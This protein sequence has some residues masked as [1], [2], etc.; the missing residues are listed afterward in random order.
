MLKRLLILFLIL[1]MF[2][3]L[4]SCSKEV[5]AKYL[6]DELGF[7]TETLSSW[8]GEIKYIEENRGKFEDTYSKVKYNP[9]NPSE[10]L[11]FINCFEGAQT[12]DAPDSFVFSAEGMSEYII[13]FYIDGAEEPALSFYY[14]KGG[15]LLTRVLRSFDEKKQIEI[16]EYEFYEPYGDLMSVLQAQREV[17]IEPVSEFS[18]L[19]YNQKQLVASVEEE[20]LSERMT[21]FN[22]VYEVQENAELG[23]IEFEIY[24]GELPEDEGT[25]CKLYDNSDI[26]GLTDEQVVLL[27]RIADE[28]G[29]PMELLI[30][31]V[32][33]NTYYTIVTV[34]YPDKELMEQL[35]LE[36]DN[37]ILLNKEDINPD[38][39]IVFLDDEGD[40]IYVVVP[41]AN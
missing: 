22:D 19:S 20:E 34:A 12:T 2:F 33:Y 13:N 3:S 5:H 18:S 37:A 9:D 29:N 30:T 21:Y 28:K 38:K 27:A 39:Y 23:E 1:M 16:V 36:A 32:E 17:A 35:G 41:F 26:P 7:S 40:V 6:F 8:E 14:W 31:F 11:S 25:G 4:A 15:N 24:D 10:L